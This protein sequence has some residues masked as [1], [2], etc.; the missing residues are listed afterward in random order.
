VEQLAL[1]WSEERV[2]ALYS[3]A[4]DSIDERDQEDNKWDAEYSVR[5]KQ[6]QE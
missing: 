2:W 1:S 5:P 3:A 4:L 6:E